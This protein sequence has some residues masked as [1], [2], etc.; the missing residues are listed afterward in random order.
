MDGAIVAK[1]FRTVFRKRLS[2]VFQNVKLIKVSISE[3]T[4]T[5]IRPDNHEYSVSPSQQCI[6]NSVIVSVYI[7][8]CF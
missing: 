7:L 2:T 1:K 6:E 8:M 5:E 4:S 3:Y